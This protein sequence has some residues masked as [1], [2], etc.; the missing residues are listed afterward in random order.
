M[1]ECE[2]GLAGV[3]AVEGQVLALAGDEVVEDRQLRIGHVN[4][5]LRSNGEDGG[6]SREAS[7]CL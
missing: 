7:S 1:D 4:G 5:Q 3:G 6:S 2:P